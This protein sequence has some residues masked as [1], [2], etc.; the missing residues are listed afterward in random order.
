MVSFRYSGIP[1]GVT[2]LGAS[3]APAR[4]IRVGATGSEVRSAYGSEDLS[5]GSIEYPEAVRDR[6]GETDRHRTEPGADGADR[7]SLGA[8][9]LHNCR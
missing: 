3:I 2:T 5:Y 6:H 7:R 9:C 4:G 1:L 8:I